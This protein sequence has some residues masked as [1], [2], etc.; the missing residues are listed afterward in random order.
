MSVFGQVFKV[1]FEGRWEGG[2][3]AAEAG[4]RVAPGSVGEAAGRLARRAPR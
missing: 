3:G 2:R 4:R 1:R